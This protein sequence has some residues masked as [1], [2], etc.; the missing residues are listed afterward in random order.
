MFWVFSDTLSSLIALAQI[1]LAV[2]IP[3]VGSHFEITARNFVILLFQ[4]DTLQI[5]LAELLDSL[6][7]F[8]LCTIVVERKCSCPILLDADPKFKADPQMPHCTGI[9]Q[10]C[11]YFI[12]FC[13]QFRIWVNSETISIAIAKVGVSLWEPLGSA[14]PEVFYCFNS[15]AFNAKPHPIMKSDLTKRYGIFQANTLL[16]VLYR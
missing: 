3:K 2:E 13:P 5:A 4:S 9:S 1:Q 6:R 7:V 16:K 12:A 10:A 14:Q 15:I 8:L 11:A